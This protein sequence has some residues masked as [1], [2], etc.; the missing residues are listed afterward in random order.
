M[1]NYLPQR[2]SA[3]ARRFPGRYP[4]SMVLQSTHTRREARIARARIRIWKSRD[5]LNGISDVVGESHCQRCDVMHES[6][7]RF[8]Q[9]HLLIARLFQNKEHKFEKGKVRFMGS[10]GTGISV[11]TNLSRNMLSIAWIWFRYY[12]HAL[13]TC[14]NNMLFWTCKKNHASCMWHRRIPV[15]IPW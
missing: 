14:I 2:Y 10:I 11:P 3:V 8:R 5:T 6:R 9:P 12:C 7:P 4:F 1:I 13:I 15:R